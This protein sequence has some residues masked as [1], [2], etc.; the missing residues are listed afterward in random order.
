MTL[1]LYSSFLLVAA[2]LVLLIWSLRDH[3]KGRSLKIDPALLEEVG[4]RHTTY[5]P[6]ISQALSRS[7]FEYLQAGGFGKL[8]SRLKRERR[9]VALLYLSDLDTDFRRLLRLARVIAALSPEVTAVQEAE[10]LRLS[11]QFMWRYQLI[12]LGFR[13]GLLL[14][15]QLNGASQ[16]VSGLAVRMETA[17]KQLGERAALAVELASALDG[18][19]VDVA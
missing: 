13:T 10:R 1:I 15:P 17:M 3:G 4:R 9:S 19:S 14:L 2:V 16:I 6:I 11:V 8:L 18:G 7:D 5:F 12:R